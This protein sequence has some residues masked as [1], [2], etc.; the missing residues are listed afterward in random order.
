VV[1][2]TF[3][4]AGAMLVLVCVVIGYRALPGA[5]AGIAL[6]G[7]LIA[8]AVRS[9]WCSPGP[10]SSVQGGSGI[11]D[12]LLSTILAGSAAS[13]MMV[14]I[15]GVC[16]VCATATVPVLS[17]LLLIGR[18]DRVVSVGPARVRQP[19]DPNCWRSTGHTAASSTLFVAGW[20]E[21][22]RAAER[23]D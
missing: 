1:C 15:V 20:A 9:A 8:L 3:L 18:D 22:V 6:L 11:R 13:L 4:A 5:T 10:G 2:W 12:V 23:E 19:V 14:A 16:T 21:P 7:Y 17:A